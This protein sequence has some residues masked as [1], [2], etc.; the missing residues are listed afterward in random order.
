[1]YFDR[2]IERGIKSI[3]EESIR[4]YGDGLEKIEV[5]KNL[6]HLKNWFKNFKYSQ[7]KPEDLKEYFEFLIDWYKKWL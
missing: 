3:S 7:I 2:L 4:D 6:F 5:F 1:M